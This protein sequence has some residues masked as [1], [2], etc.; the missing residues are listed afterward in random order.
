M[1]INLLVIPIGKVTQII[2]VIIIMFLFLLTTFMISPI[3]LI[4]LL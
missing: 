4:A 2:L 1:D 3:P